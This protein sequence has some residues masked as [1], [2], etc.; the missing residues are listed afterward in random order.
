MLL[1]LLCRLDS[2]L[3]EMKHHLSHD[4]IIFGGDLNHSPFGFAQER[5]FRDRHGGDTHR[6]LEWREVGA[7][8]QSK[9]EAQFSDRQSDQSSAITICE[10]IGRTVS[11][12]K[13][14]TSQ[15]QTL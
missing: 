11:Q 2:W 7:A 1:M 13:F 6:R 9:K 15:L 12:E 4:H 10:S 8:R 3:V 5:H 14:N